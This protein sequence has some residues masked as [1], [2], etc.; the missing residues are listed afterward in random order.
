MSF[1]TLMNLWLEQNRRLPE[2]DADALKNVGVFTLYKIFLIYIYIC[3][4]IYILCVCVCLC[5]VHLLVWILNLCT[6]LSRTP[7]AILLVTGLQKVCMYNVLKRFNSI[8]RKLHSSHN[9]HNLTVQ[10][11]AY[12]PYWFA[13]MACVSLYTPVTRFTDEGKLRSVKQSNRNRV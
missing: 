4:Y 10:I 13:S 12:T 3:I 9:S 2:D 6:K 11:N 5:V 7:F 8:S 1:T